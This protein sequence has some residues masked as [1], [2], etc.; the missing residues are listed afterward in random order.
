MAGWSSKKILITVRTYPVPARKGIEVSCT[1][2]VTEDGQWIR[3]FPV[4]YRFLEEDKRFRKYQ[5]IEVSVTKAKNDPRPESHNLRVDTI[6]ILSSVSPADGWRARKD[7]LRHLIRPSMCALERY[8][9]EH[10]SP[11]LG[12]FKPG[13]IERL[14]IEPT[15]ANWSLKEAAILNQQL[16][17]FQTGPAQPLE[18]IPFEFR[19]KFQCDH[20]SCGGHDMTCF[21]WEVGQSYRRWRDRYGDHWEP[22]FRERYERDVIDKYDTHFYVGTLHQYP[23]TWIIVGLFYPPRQAVKDLFEQ[24]KTA[25]ENKRGHAVEFG[26]QV[27]YWRS[28][29]VCV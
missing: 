25:I 28:I 14:V 21:D 22:K 8:R 16:L 19:Y 29:P 7:K 26:Q 10:G 2:G 17:P 1:G 24:A 6:R 23:G 11:T 4:P 20:R 18:K 13:R 5:W 9:K 27:S 3:L 12:L 15:A